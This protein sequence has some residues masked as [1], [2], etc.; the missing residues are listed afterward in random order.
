MVKKTLNVQRLISAHKAAIV[1]LRKLTQSRPRP[2]V[3]YECPSKA[4]SATVTFH[5]SSQEGES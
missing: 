2:T 1:E 3:R 4:L 5:N